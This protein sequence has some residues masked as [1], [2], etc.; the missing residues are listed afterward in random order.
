VSNTGKPSE[1]YYLVRTRK[2]VNRDALLS[3]IRAGGNGSISTVEIEV[4]DALAKENGE[5][6][7]E[8]KRQEQPA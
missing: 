4:G 5:R 8:R 2:S 3:A 1:L 7:R 6:R